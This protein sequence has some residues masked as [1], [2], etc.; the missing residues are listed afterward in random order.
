MT[1]TYDHWLWGDLPVVVI[2]TYKEEQRVDVEQ[3]ASNGKT[4]FQ[5]VRFDKLRKL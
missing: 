2:A 4:C 1:V 3:Q 5:K